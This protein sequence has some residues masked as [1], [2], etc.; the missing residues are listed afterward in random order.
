MI[1]DRDSIPLGARGWIGNGQS[2]ALVAADGTIDWW[3][4]EEP[5]APA[6]FAR[7]LD[8]A[9]GA[10]RIAPA[11]T[12]V[13]GL[14]A[15][16][17]VARR[18][19]LGA[20]RYLSGTNVLRTALAVTDG[21]I[22]IT[23]FLPWSGT[24]D[25]PTGTLV[26]LVH[27]RRGPVSVEIEV[28]PGA[29]F[30]PAKRV[31][32]WSEGLVFDGTVVHTGIPPHAIPEG[33]DFRTGRGGAT[34]LATATLDAGQWMVV[35][36]W[37]QSGAG[38]ANGGP[39]S[40]DGAQRALAA[41]IDAWR[42]WVAPATVSGPFAETIERSLLVI[43]GLTPAAGGAPVA[44]ATTSLPRRPGGERQSDAR[45]VRLRDAATAALTLRRAG[46]DESAET[47]EGWLRSA[48]E[49]DA[50]QPPLPAALAPDGT[51]APATDE[52]DV[53]GWRRSQPVVRGVPS[54][55]LDLD[56]VGDVWDAVRAAPVSPATGT[57]RPGSDPPGPLT[58]AWGELACAADWLAEHWS[59]PDSGLWGGEH[60]VRLVAS[61]V[62]S[63]RALDR[64]ARLARDAN[65]LDLDAVGWQQ[66]AKDVLAWLEVEGM[67]A[68]GGLRR[69]PIPEDR[70][71][72]A[73]LRV[74]W[75]GPWPSRHP[76]VA[77][78][79]DRVLG[80]LSSG[81]LVYRL[82]P[83]VDVAFAGPD[84][85]D[86]LASVWAVRA[87]AALGRWE[88]AHDRMERLVAFGRGTPGGS[89]GSRSGV[90]GEAADPTSGELLGNLPS[91]AVHLALVDAAYDLATGPA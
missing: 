19:R 25:R 13:G 23:D 35:T 83:T 64:A 72:A 17:R 86:L 69:D 43:G 51:R 6:V 49:G 76:V 46:L 63:W 65:P 47:A 31:E 85:P 71:D 7:L 82:P 44:G 45:V 84:S 9:G 90:L 39:L 32:V 88:D 36:A 27:A 40:L 41:T 38:A 91:A 54:D 8:P 24:A 66:A 77:A 60:R 55:Q 5:D 48:L 80:Q 81:P 4:P 37:S 20:Q 18:R 57:R 22:E 10:L 59:Q 68:T 16:N 33:R 52:I 2:H 73:L 89:T 42:S 78:T 67:A 15:G 56:V 53:A 34:W 14:P 30:A 50:G 74:A 26:R 11:T 87:E 75:N 58:G 70:A 61:R 28:A 79:V 12:S 1:P 29:D 21:S 62:Q 3:C